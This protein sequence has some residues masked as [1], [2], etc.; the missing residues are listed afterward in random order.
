MTSFFRQLSTSALL[1]GVFLAPQ[2][3]AQTS[4]A[5]GSIADSLALNGA[6]GPAYASNGRLAISVHG[7]L[8]LQRTAGAPFTQ[9]TTGAGWDRDPA[10]NADGSAIVFASDR[11]GNYDLYQL[12][13]GAD[14]A[15]GAIARL[16]TSAAHETMPTVARDGRI[17]FLRGAGNGARVVVRDA[18]GTERRVTAASQTER[19]PRFA[20]NGTDLAFLSVTEAGRR[21]HIWSVPA[22]GA[23]QARTSQAVDASAESISWAWDGERL[24][25]STRTGIFMV[26]RAGGYSNFVASAR[27]QTAWSPDGKTIAVA[28]FDE[29]TSAYNGD[30]DRGA[31]RSA[32]V[33][34]L[35]SRAERLVYVAAPVAPNQTTTQ[36]ADALRDLRARTDRNGEAF[37]RLWDQSARLYFSSTEAKERRAQWDKVRTVMRPRAIAA[38][39]DSALDIVLHETLQQRPPLR[40]VARGRAAVSSAHPV[41]TEAG[42]EVMRAG[43]NVVDAAVAVSFALG[44]V[45]PDAS[46]I[47]G[48]GEMV[49]ALKSMNKPT[50]IEFMSRVPEDAGLSNTSLLVNGRYPSDGP[51]LVNVPGTVAG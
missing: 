5:A 20:P 14:G 36:T 12:A 9:L 16:T 26:P 13:V 24:A 43:G 27:G 47:A 33:R 10:W 50:L 41:A 39:S 23:A 3:A 30:P 38:V 34:P 45:E 37:D 31:D 35:L 29:P 8:Y 42:L 28:V 44:V 22:S 6:R 48:Y 1:C 18:D 51:V 49:I 4:P 19:S 2:L 15:P 46:G 7:H 11:A 32:V 17:A 21:L 25:V 40:E